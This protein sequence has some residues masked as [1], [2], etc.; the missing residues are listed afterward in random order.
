MQHYPY[1]VVFVSLAS[2]Y[3]D[4]YLQPSHKHSTPPRSFSGLSEMPSYAPTTRL[5]ALMT[6]VITSILIRSPTPRHF[7]HPKS[8]AVYSQIKFSSTTAISRSR[9]SRCCTYHHSRLR[10][11]R[12]ALVACRSCPSETANL[13]MYSH[14]IGSTLLL[15][16]LELL[17]AGV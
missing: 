4:S 8:R 6:I 10:A 12:L 16:L 13:A 2:G 15:R 1:T 5:R 7:G 17:P 14:T 3:V 11:Q 9:M